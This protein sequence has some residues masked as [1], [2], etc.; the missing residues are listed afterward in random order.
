MHICKYRI[1]ELKAVDVYDVSCDCAVSAVYHNCIDIVGQP[2]MQTLFIASWLLRS[3]LYG[4]VYTHKH[5]YWSSSFDLQ[6]VTVL[7]EP[8]TVYYAHTVCIAGKS[9]TSDHTDSSNLASPNE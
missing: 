3:A 5:T 1:D 8:P 7:T 6:L 4:Y 9:H 2:I